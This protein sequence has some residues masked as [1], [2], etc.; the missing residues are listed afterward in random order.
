MEFYAKIINSFQTLAVFAKSSK[1]MTVSEFTSG[2][3]KCLAKQHLLKQFFWHLKNVFLDHLYLVLEMLEIAFYLILSAF[4]IS[5]I[6]IIFYHCNSNN[7]FFIH[8]TQNGLRSYSKTVTL[9]SLLY[10][11]VVSGHFAV[12]GENFPLEN[13]VL[14]FFIMWK[15]CLYF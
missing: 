1:S 15:L 2:F 4:I 13:K 12:L 10:W 14:K 3:F 11:I 8:T 9:L 7:Y 6:N 5:F